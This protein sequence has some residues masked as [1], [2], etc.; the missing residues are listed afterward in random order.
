MIGSVVSVVTSNILAIS[1][2]AVFIISAVDVIHAVALPGL[3]V[4]ADAIP[5]RVVQCRI[6][7]PCSGLIFGQCSELCG[8]LHGYM[9]LSFLIVKWLREDIS[10]SSI[11]R[12]ENRS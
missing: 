2:T 3:G 9:P 6:E 1:A 11:S 5:G 10:Y 12:S 7:A 4:K 8:P